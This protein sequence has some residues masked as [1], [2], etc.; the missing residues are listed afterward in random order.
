MPSVSAIRALT[1]SRKH[2][3]DSIITWTTDVGSKKCVKMIRLELANSITATVW[4][5]FSNCMY[6]IKLASPLYGMTQHESS[7]GIPGSW[8]YCL[9]NFW[10]Y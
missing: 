4:P 5:Q 10:K 7:T 9:Q 8:Q 3:T 6:Y 2:G 1:G